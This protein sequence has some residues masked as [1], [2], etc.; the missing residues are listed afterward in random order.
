MSDNLPLFIEY[1]AKEQEQA[2]VKLFEE[3][4]GRTLYP[5]QDERLLISI[6]EYKAALLVNLF[7]EAARLNLTQYSRGLILDCIGEMFNTPRL[8]GNFGSDLLQINLNTT[9]T[10]DLTLEARCSQIRKR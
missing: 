2:L 3:E 8:Q 5:A 4:T 9:F 6:I 1:N 10:N 7:N